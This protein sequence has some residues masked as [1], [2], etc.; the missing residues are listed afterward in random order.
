MNKI[1]VI[2]K[3]DTMDN[4]ENDTLESKLKFGKNMDSLDSSKNEQQKTQIMEEFS[5]DNGQKNNVSS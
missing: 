5:I 1:Q 3:I 2:A 4:V